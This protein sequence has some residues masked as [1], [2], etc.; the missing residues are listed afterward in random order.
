[1]CIGTLISTLY[2]LHFTDY[3]VNLHVTR[4]VTRTAQ[5]AAICI[6][7]QFLCEA[8]SNIAGT[9]WFAQKLV[10]TGFITSQARNS[11]V[12]TLGYSDMEKCS[13]L[14]SAVE[15]QLKANAALFYTFID[16]LKSEDA[17][18]WV[19]DVITKS[20]GMRKLYMSC[21]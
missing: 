14:L 5:E 17:L 8:I 20:Y 2:S 10:E 12:H 3:T 18:M 9:T 1:M 7:S 21:L 4:F 19:V 6:N 13:R 16:I 11:I 15:S